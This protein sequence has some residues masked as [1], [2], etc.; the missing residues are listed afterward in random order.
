MKV[1]KNLYRQITSTEN[2]FEAWSIFKRD[3]RNRPDVEVFEKNVEYELFKLGRELRAKCYR[4]GPYRMFMIHD[5]KLRCIH[6]ATVRDRV[7]HHAVFKILSPI[8]E[9]TFISTSFSCRVGKGTHKGV[10]YLARTLR[11]VSRNGTQPCYAL[12]CDVRKF[13]DSID[14][15]ILLDIF[16]KR[17]TDP[18]TR[19]LVREIIGSYEDVGF[20]REREREREREQKC[21]KKRRANRQS[22]EPAFRQRVYE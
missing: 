17:V 19:W 14:H 20:T 4:H 2:L 7:L 21:A 22:H 10:E 13:F 6:K 11:A 1:Y 9:P 5:P 8:F 15:D 3:K 16:E 12:K 18:D